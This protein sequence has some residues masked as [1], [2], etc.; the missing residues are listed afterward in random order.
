MVAVQVLVVTVTM[1]IAV[2]AVVLVVKVVDVVGPIISMVM[3]EVVIVT[4]DHWTSIAGDVAG[5]RG[6]AELYRYRT[7][8]DTFERYF[9]VNHGLSHVS[10]TDSG[11]TNRQT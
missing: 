7:V 6:D 5:A 2:M 8:E 9:E 11:W 4:L 1:S 3:V 10:H